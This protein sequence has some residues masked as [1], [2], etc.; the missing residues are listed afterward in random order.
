MALTQ[1]TG[2]GIGSLN[3]PAFLAKMSANQDISDATDTKVAFNTEVFDTDNKYDHSTN[4][5][6]TPAVAGTYFLYTQ[7]L[8]ITND[9]T[10]L[11]DFIFSIRKNN[12]SIYST[13]HNPSANYANQV[14]LNIQVADVANTTDYYEVF[15]Y[16]DD[17]SGDPDISSSI[18]GG[19]GG[20]IVSFFG[21]HKLIGV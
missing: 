5:R 17:L 9:N 4:Y 15:V 3:T 8:A 11:V 13:R 1:I 16:V 18:G 21:A 2:D 6:F 19:W 14:A 10:Q 7:V 12:S 20:S